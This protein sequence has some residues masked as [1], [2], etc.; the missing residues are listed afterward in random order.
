MDISIIVPL[1]N[2]GSRLSLLYRSLAPVLSQYGKCEIIFIDDGS[3]DNTPDIIE[4]IEKSDARIRSVRFPEN[5]G[6]YAALLAGYKCSKGAIVV[7]LDDDAFEELKRIPEF[8]GKIEDGY[9]AVFGWRTKTGYPVFRKVGSFLFNAWFSLLIG[10]RIHDLGSPV[11]AKSRKIVDEMASFDD[12]TC[13]PLQYK[14]YRIAEIRLAS[15]FSRLFPS[16]Y[17]AEKR[18]AAGAALIY[19]AMFKGKGL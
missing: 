19:H 1:Y 8:I 6:Q 16:R 4:G 12:M 18:V 17:T 11:K 15:R 5:R 10:T 2:S 13:F 3:T 7:S 14:R 9:D